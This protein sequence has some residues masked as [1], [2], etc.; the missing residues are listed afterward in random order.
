[1]IK[2]K[3]NVDFLKT[4]C[5]CKPKLRDTLISNA[6]KEQVITLCECILNVLNG[7]VHID[8][9]LV[10]KLKKYK[11]QF[12]LL[13]GKHSTSKKRKAIIKQH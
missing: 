11:K 4:L 5:Q 7:N 8:D 6:G 12:R 10:K 3:R 1:M 9:A 2:V 13:S